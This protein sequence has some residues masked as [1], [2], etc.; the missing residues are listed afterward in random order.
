[1]LVNS[2]VDKHTKTAEAAVM[3]VGAPSLEGAAMAQVFVPTFLFSIFYPLFVLMYHL[4]N[5][6]NPV[7]P[8]RGGGQEVGPE[9]ALPDPRCRSCPDTPVL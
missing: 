4:V 6:C 3:S 9:D 1:M 5:L 2:A 7:A 8:R